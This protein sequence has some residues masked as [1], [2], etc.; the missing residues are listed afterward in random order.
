MKLLYNEAGKWINDE[1]NSASFRKS[2]KLA[3]PRP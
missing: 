2:E 1:P 3:K